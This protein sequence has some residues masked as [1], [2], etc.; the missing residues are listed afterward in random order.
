MKPFLCLALAALSLSGC[1]AFRTA[2]EPDIVLPLYGPYMAVWDSTHHYIGN[3]YSSK[4]SMFVEFAESDSGAALP[5]SSVPLGP[6]HRFCDPGHGSKS[7]L[8][9]KLFDEEDRFVGAS[10][11]SLN[12]ETFE[13]TRTR[14]SPDSQR[15]AFRVL[16]PLTKTRP[17]EGIVVSFEGMQSTR[18]STIVGTLRC[19]PSTWGGCGEHHGVVFFPDTTQ[20]F[21][22]TRPKPTTVPECK[23][24]P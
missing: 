2:S 13:A 24:L 8:E 7:H 22:R 17:N 16:M 21:Y 1:D 4:I 12:P 10:G 9:Y 14:V 19:D 18:D 20:E 3:V 15:V 6:T 11:R 5:Q 23:P